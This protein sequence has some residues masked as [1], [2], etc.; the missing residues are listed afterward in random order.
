ML[1]LRLIKRINLKEV[2]ENAN[3]FANLEFAV[4][5][6]SGLRILRFHLIVFQ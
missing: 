1:L 3:K 6:I 2:D 4:V 5:K